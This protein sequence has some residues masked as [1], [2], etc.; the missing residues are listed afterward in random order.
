MFGQFAERFTNKLVRPAHQLNF[1]FC[2]QEDL[3]QHRLIGLDA[4][5]TSRTDTARVE[6]TVIVAHHQMVLYLLKRIDDD[7]HEDEQ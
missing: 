3:H 2:L 6:Q 1:I 4:T 5:L 7:T